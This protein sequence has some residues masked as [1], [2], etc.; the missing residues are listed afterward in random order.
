MVDLKVQGFEEPENKVGT[1]ESILAGVASGFFKIPEGIISLGASLIDLGA[2]TNNA[3]K[4][5]AFFDEINPFDEAAEATTAGKITETLVNIGI[6]GGIA[7]TKGAQLANA[8]IKGK[9]AKKYFQ[10]R[11]E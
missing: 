3:A 11:Q 6:P 4:V 10:L 9:K 8:A 1:I 5:E 2:G 7:F